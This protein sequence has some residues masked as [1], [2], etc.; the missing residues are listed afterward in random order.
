MTPLPRLDTPTG[1]AH[2]YPNRSPILRRA[3]MPLKRWAIISILIVLLPGTAP[4]KKILITAVDWYPYMS[5]SMEGN[6]FAC[7]VVTYAFLAVGY[8][9]EYI[10]TTWEDSRDKVIHGLVAGMIGFADETEKTPVLQLSDP[11]AVS[12]EVF[13]FKRRSSSE[14][15]FKKLEDL[16]EYRIGVVRGS[17]SLPTFKK[18]G[19]TLSMSSDANFSFKKLY[20]D[21][22]DLVPENEF[23]GWAIINR[24]YPDE[25]YKF[26]ETSRS[27]S[28][29]K[30]HLV[31]AAS[32]PA[33][34]KIL[35]TFNRGLEI[36]NKEGIYVNLL[37]KYI[38]E[39]KIKTPKK[40]Y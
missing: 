31:M 17:H 32:N 22:V 40:P 25:I 6:G 23:V 8:E 12:K 29:S 24:L 13:F 3:T 7:E 5:R 30:V 15:S 18:A 14:I 11:I 39:V 26:D 19:L 27:I 1:L 33:S 2:N 35:E 4:A 37:R 34:N 36:L 16:K 21:M 38:K 20:I 28:E 10:F 9:T